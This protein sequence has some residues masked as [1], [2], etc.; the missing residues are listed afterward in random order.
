[1]MRFNFPWAGYLVSVVIAPVVVMLLVNLIG[2]GFYRAVHGDPVLDE[3]HIKDMPQRMRTIFSLVR[4]APTVVLLGGI[5]ILGAVLY[6]LDGVMTF[7]LKLGDSVETIA[8]WATV[9]LVI[10][11]CLSYFARM[12]FMYKTRR[13]EEEYAFRRDV[14]DRTGMIIL[15]QKSMLGRD[16][17][18]LALGGLR[19]LPAGSVEVLPSSTSGSAGA[20]NAPE[21][22]NASATAGVA[23][24]AAADQADGD[25][26]DIEATAVP[27]ASSEGAATEAAAANR[28]A[29]GANRPP[30][31]DG[32]GD[33]DTAQG[34]GNS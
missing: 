28:E 12:W 10:A 4:G 19:E 13:L 1:M 31:I 22:G 33:A 9:G 23:A 18:Q 29:T 25:V 32:A 2:I 34:K 21:T 5:L 17:P 6:Y 30:H 16:A 3:E 11:W 14:L 15:D 20:G 24:T 27:A 26:V 7:L 8:I